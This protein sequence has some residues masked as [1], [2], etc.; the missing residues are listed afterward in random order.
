MKKSKN[1]EFTFLHKI[2]QRRKRM[3]IFDKLEEG[4]TKAGIWVPDNKEPIKQEPKQDDSIKNITGQLLPIQ[5]P[6]ILQE[7]NED[8]FKGILSNINSSVKV[9]NIAIL[10]DTADKMKS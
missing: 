5:S 6:S 4:A 1:L 9:N 8:I 3:G 2:K 10:L 7:P